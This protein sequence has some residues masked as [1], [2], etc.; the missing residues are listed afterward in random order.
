V[1]PASSQLIASQ[2][3]AVLTRDFKWAASITL[4]V[5]I[6]LA[7]A[8]FYLP[9][10]LGASPR[11]AIFLPLAVPVRAVA[12]LLSVTGAF[13]LWKAAQDFTRAGMLLG[14]GWCL[15]GLLLMRAAGT[16][17]PIYSGAALADVFPAAGRDA[18]L[19]S[20]A[21]YD[22]SLIFYLQRTATLVRYRGELD[23]GLK[24][25]PE[26]E[27]EDL[28]RFLKTWS[29]ESQAFAVME[30]GMYDELNRR[31]VAMQLVGRSFGKVLVARL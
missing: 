14:V 8:S 19:Y 27:I 29:A 7:A 1:I 28:D 21:T 10:L 6:G 5:G 24:R 23:Y 31:G 11:N 2:A 9:S 3:Q 26:R 17:A 13:V 4:L 25:A 16:A 18:P 22:Q 20:V 15:A 12:V 30:N